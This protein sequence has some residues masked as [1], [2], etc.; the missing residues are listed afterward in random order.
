MAEIFSNITLER[1]TATNET[2][3][4]LWNDV[5]LTAG[6]KGGVGI[7]NNG[8]LDRT[9]DGNTLTF[10]LDNSAGNMNATQGW[11]ALSANLTY[12]DIIR[13]GFWYAGEVKYLPLYYIPPNGIK[14]SAGVYGPK[15][16]TVTATDWFG[17]MSLYPLDSISYQVNKRIDEAVEL[18]LQEL[19]AILRPTYKVFY[20][21]D[22]TFADVFD[23][24]K[25]STTVLA[26]LNKLAISEMGYIYMRGSS[27][28]GNVMVV[29]NRLYRN[30]NPA[31]TAYYKRSADTTDIF[32]L[33]NGTDQF[34]IANAT[35]KLLLTE[36][37]TG[38]FDDADLDVTREYG[39]GTGDDYANYSKI[40]L[41]PRV[42]DADA[43]TVLWT[44]EGAIL[45]PAG[46]TLEPIEAQYRD[47][48]NRTNKVNCIA[49]TSPVR[50]TDF[51]G[52][53]NEDGTGTNLTAFL[54]V[55]VDFEPAA[56]RIVLSNTGGTDLY[57]GGDTLFRL[58]GQ[59]VYVFDTIDYLLE[60]PA[61]ETV[62][63]HNL[64]MNMPYFS[65]TDGA[66]GLLLQT[67]KNAANRV[68]NVRRYPMLANRNAA[69]M[70]AFMCLEP[71]TKA[72]FAEGMTMSSGVDF[73]IQGYEFEIINKEYVYWSP[74]L[75]NHDNIPEL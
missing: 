44:M 42:V 47:P 58:R 31:D 73:W 6:V 32:L 22:E 26:E 35:D 61:S 65:R 4:D 49:G 52:F 18:V 69:N 62:G 48:N 24:M 19:P 60:R 59:G 55:D 23:L 40:T 43:T 66:M 11:Y 27:F 68:T 75:F 45:V 50:T 38:D 46:E 63:R 10:T 51:Q 12:G 9:P 67:L 74:C 1:R 25:S 15:T 53:A 56:A 57:T 20:T 37:Q 33:A 72:T 54:Q 29:E 2:W 41:T 28:G 8:F 14:I 36:T 64:N 17:L 39:Y 16:V 5:I 3:T 7:L 34:L 21:G 70:M 71:G 30:S 13:V